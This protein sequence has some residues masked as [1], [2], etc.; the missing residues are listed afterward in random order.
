M[1]I[2]DNINE[3]TDIIDK[4]IQLNKIEYLLEHLDII[5]IYALYYRREEL[6]MDFF[7][8]VPKWYWDKSN[9]VDISVYLDMLPYMTS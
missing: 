4:A 8:R 1:D 3:Q 5:S 9:T 6:G 7:K 2:P